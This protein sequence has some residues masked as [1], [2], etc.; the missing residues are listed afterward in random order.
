MQLASQEYHIRGL[1]IAGHIHV[2]CWSIRRSRGTLIS[3][4]ALCWSGIRTIACRRS[5]HNIGQV[6]P[7]WVR[8]IIELSRE[9]IVRKQ[10][11]IWN[12]RVVLE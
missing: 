4:L 6:V 2:L 9:S 11:L 3:W 1:D 12:P 5:G 7:V 10:Y 8:K